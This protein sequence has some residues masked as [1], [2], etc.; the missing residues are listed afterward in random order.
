MHSERAGDERDALL[1]CL[2]LNLR[3][4]RR[5]NALLTVALNE[6]KMRVKKVKMV[7][8]EQL[9]EMSLQRS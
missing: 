3:V 2:E 4:V 9:N 8:E 5:E 6:C 7:D 1:A